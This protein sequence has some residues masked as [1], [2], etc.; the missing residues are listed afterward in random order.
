MRNLILTLICSSLLVTT[1]ARAEYLYGFANTYT[2]YLSWTNGDEGWTG[3]AQDVSET[4]DDHVTLGIEAGAGFSWGEMYGFYELEKLNMSSNEQSNAFKL[5]AHYKVA[6]NITAYGS[7]Y[8]YSDSGFSAID[9]QNTV[10]G[11]GYIGWASDDFWFKPFFGAHM[12]KSGQTAETGYDDIDGLNGAILGWNLGWN[13]KVGEQKFM[14]TNWHEFEL[15]RND[16]YSQYQYG[17]TGINGGAAIWYD[18]TD[19]IY[20]GVQ[21]RYFKNKLGVDG[22]GDAIIFRIGI[23]L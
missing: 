21:Y 17:E 2:D 14:L 5:T 15:N 23:H 1:S 13:F 10:V 16:E 9:E 22:Y 6:G 12:V 19:R 8:D 11:I 20:T 18:I 3:G 4:R 7:V